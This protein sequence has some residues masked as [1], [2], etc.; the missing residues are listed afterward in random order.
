MDRTTL[1]RGLFGYRASAV[2]RFVS[3]QDARL[4]HAEGRIT[5][6]EVRVAKLRGELTAARE[7]LEGRERRVAELR[8]RLAELERKADE[9][10][11]ARL[12]GD[13]MSAVLAASEQAARGIVDRARASV[14]AEMTDVAGALRRSR[15]ER[16]RYLAWYSATR[17]KLEALRAR[18]ERLRGSVARVPELI[19]KAL[20]EV[21]ESVV[22]LH[23]DL[24]VALEI[25]PR[26]SRPSDRVEVLPEPETS[27]R[28]SD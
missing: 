20:A 28:S 27:A 1:R 13:E 6:A 16:D 11:V 10:A 26:P 18:I 21:D 15:M 7:A 17:Q 22:A 3:D 24:R 14:L 8:G 2:H 25:D 23:G 9:S 5:A 19:G 12:A 4:R